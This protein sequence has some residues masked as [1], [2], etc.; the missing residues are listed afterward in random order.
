MGYARCDVSS[1]EQ[2]EGEI[3]F[4]VKIDTLKVLIIL[5]VLAYSVDRVDILLEME[6]WAEQAA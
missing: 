4:V 1:R 6:Q 5:T 3:P 2:V